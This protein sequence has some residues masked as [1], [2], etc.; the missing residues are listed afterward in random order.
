MKTYLYSKDESHPL[1]MKISC[2]KGLK[3]LFFIWY[4]KFTN[5]LLTGI[6]HKNVQYMSPIF[7]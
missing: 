2:V 4:E 1:N 5:V 3:V 7:L 6:Q